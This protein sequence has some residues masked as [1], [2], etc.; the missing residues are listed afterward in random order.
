MRPIYLYS[1]WI[2]AFTLLLGTENIRAQEDVQ[3][4]WLTFE[5]LSDSLQNNP[6][7]VLISFHTEWCVYCRKMHREVF[8]HPKVVE[9]INTA[10]YAVKFDAESTA[11]VQ[12]DGQTFVNRRATK[13]WSGYHDIALL[14]GARNGEFTVPVTLI[15]DADFRVIERRFE[16]LHSEA[17]LHLL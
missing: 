16:Y 2:C 13:K 12:F 5:Q 1:Y 4:N 7:K 17:L 9:K 3:I 6:K 11:P 14:L 10:Y 15:L 8:T